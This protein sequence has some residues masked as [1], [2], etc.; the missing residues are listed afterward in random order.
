MHVHLHYKKGSFG[1]FSLLSH[2]YY[3]SHD[4]DNFDK[5]KKA[6]LGLLTN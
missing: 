1:I 4:V 5:K 6:K 2:S 3:N